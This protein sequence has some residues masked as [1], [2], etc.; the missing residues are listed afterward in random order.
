MLALRII[1]AI[2]NGM[3]TGI[4]SGKLLEF[5]PPLL[6][7]PWETAM[8]VKTSLQTLVNKYRFIDISKFSGTLERYNLSIA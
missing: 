6:I 5:K 1:R 3:N 7:A 2:T 4:N 8:P